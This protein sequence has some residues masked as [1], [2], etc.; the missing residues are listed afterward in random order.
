ML[1]QEPDSAMKFYHLAQSHMLLNDFEH[2]FE[3]YESL[4]EKYQFIL[5]DEFREQVNYNKGICLFN[6]ERYTEALSLFNNCSNIPESI[7]HIGAINFLFHKDYIAAKHR[8]IR[9]LEN[10]AKPSFW[11]TNRNKCRYNAWHTLLKIRLIPFLEMQK[12]AQLEFPNMRK[13]EC[14]TKNT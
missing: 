5:D 2:A 4:V 13:Q 10:D 3:I 9:Y 11:S 14:V 12:K 8:F 1:Q 7:Y 6:L